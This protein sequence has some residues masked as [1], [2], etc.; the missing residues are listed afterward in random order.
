MEVIYT[1][2]VTGTKG[3]DDRNYSHNELCFIISDGVVKEIKPT[4]LLEYDQYRQNHHD[5]HLQSRQMVLL[6]WSLSWCISLKSRQ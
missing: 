6:H 4:Q 1:H 5:V 2:L 3:L